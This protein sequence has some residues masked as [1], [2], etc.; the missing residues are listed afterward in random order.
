MPSDLFDELD[1]P[2]KLDIFDDL[3][4]PPARRDIFD[5]TENDLSRFGDYPSAPA[6]GSSP[7]II[8]ARPLA[9]ENL[10][11]QIG[12]ERD[13]LQGIGDDASRLAD[14][15]LMTPFQAGG[16][17]VR[18]GVADIASGMAGSPEYSGNI[19]AALSGDTLP[20]DRVLAD[21]SKEAPGAATL[22]KI[23]QGIAGSAPLIAVM[24]Q[25][26]LG[27]LVA[28]GFTADMLRHAGPE[29]TALGEEMG[30]PPEE[31]DYDKIT[32]A[33]STLAQTTAFAPLAGAHAGGSTGRAIVDRIA[34]RQAAIRELS[35]QL[36]DEPLEFKMTPDETARL[37][38]G[39]PPRAPAEPVLPELARTG[40]LV[41]R[42]LQERTQRII[43][44]SQTPA[45]D[46]LRAQGNEIIPGA[47]A[48]EFRPGGGQ[49]TGGRVS[50]NRPAEEIAPGRTTAE[51]PEDSL[52]VA[53]V[54]QVSP[55]ASRF[56]AEFSKPDAKVSNMS[57]T[58]DA[59]T[60]VKTG[61]SLKNVA[62]L[63]ALLAAN[64]A[65]RSSLQRLRAKQRSGEKLTAE[66]TQ[67]F[68]GNAG[69]VQFPREAVEVATNYG[70]WSEA[71]QALGPRPRPL[72]ERPLDWQKSPEVRDWLERNGE[73]LGLDVSEIRQGSLKTTA[74]E[75][76]EIPE[77]PSMP[78]VQK[79][80]RELRYEFP[81]G[82]KVEIV[83]NHHAL[84]DA[85]HQAAY[86]QGANP[87][88][89]KGYVDGKTVYI[90]R[91]MLDSAADIRQLFLHEQAGHFATDR[92]L[93]PKLTK[94][95]ESVHDSFTKDALMEE[96]RMLYKK[97]DKARLGREFVARLSENP[98][99][100]PTAWNKI[101]AQFRSW[102]RDIGWVKKVSENDIRVLLQR[103]MDS[104][105][106]KEGG[107]SPDEISLSVARSAK[108]AAE[109][110]YPREAKPPASG[111]A[112]KPRPATV[113]EG[114]P[115]PPDITGGAERMRQSAARATTSEQVPP[116]VQER[117]AE[118]PESFYKS[119]KYKS[120]EEAV[121]AA[122]DAELAAVPK[123]S[124]FH[125]ASQLELSRRLFEQGRTEEGYEVFKN[126]SRQGTEWGQ[127]INQF[128]ML[129]GTT[130]ANIIDL[131]N[132]GLKEAG[133]DP[134]TKK[135]MEV[136]GGKAD[137]SIQANKRLENAKKKWEEDPTDANA[138]AAQKALDEAAK[139]DLE[140]QRSINNYKIRTW[141]QMLK[142]FAQGNPLTP[143]SHVANFVGNTVGAS[144]E[145]SSRGVATLID[146]IRNA[147]TGTGRKITVGPSIAR[148]AAEGYGR[149][150]K[151]SPK[152]L[153]RGTGD[154]IKGESRL[155]LQPFRSFIKAF[156]KNPDV[157]TV[158]GKVPLNERIR[159]ATEG[160]FGIPPETMLRLLSGADR[161]PYEAARARLIAEQAKLKGLTPKQ[162]SMAQKFP[163]L[164]FDK[165]TLAQIKL[166]SADAVFQRPSVAVDKLQSLIRQ[167]GGDWG[168]F[169]FTLLVSP[170]KL[171]PWNLVVRTLQYNPVW[172][173]AESAIKARR[174]DTRGA[175][176]SAGRMVI[177]SML[178]ATGYYLYKNGLIGPSL[179]GR[180][181]SQK[182]RMLSGEV[183]P[184]N[185]VNLSGLDR[186]R[187]GESPAF[188][189]GDETIDLTRGG[190]AAGAILSSVANIGRK[191]ENKPEESGTEFAMSLLRDSTLEQ[192][193]FTINQSF[194]KGVTGALDAIQHGNFGPYVTGVE[195]MLLNV[196][197]P[198]TLTA[199]S[200]ATRNYAPDMKAEGVAD[201]FGKVVKNRFGILGADDYLPAK[202]D[203]FGEKMP[204]TPEGRNS[205]LYHLFDISKGRQVT[206]DPVKLELYRLWRKTADAS[207]IPSIPQRD[208]TAENQT[209]PLSNAL[210]SEFSETV[211]RRRKEIA[212]SLVQ[213][214]HFNELTDEQKIKTMEDAWREGLDYGKAVF[215]DKHQSELKAKQPR[216]GFDK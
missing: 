58:P 125:V 166:E 10:Q 54:P 73:Q 173:A 39:L 21:V 89:I 118:A 83:E 211:G 56:I 71:N 113:S 195:N 90:N 68:F 57:D 183:L 102:L 180:S 33:L 42:A 49:T 177:G 8:D 150:L 215:L 214:P 127:N 72:G 135:Q 25:G 55:E 181:E 32:T 164:F 51:K 212:D 59:V 29:A 187:K 36:K 128:K 146:T 82:L 43:D 198:N 66:E 64:N 61:L 184:P 107:M 98:K 176:I 101:V 152:I 142:A 60:T 144:M 147:M 114:A 67:E 111:E 136:L 86:R 163:E 134:L 50:F 130:P 92:I 84:P 143:M 139:S 199:L 41:D 17:I 193:N 131:V 11:S 172:A 141:P 188:K 103:S 47:A 13:R 14:V 63:D 6:P 159:L 88:G 31:R 3:D 122:G 99:S 174:G 74:G 5:E 9:R 123:E 167:K 169:A 171:T 19:T 108:E 133:R 149:G 35:R 126:V 85:S 80:L 120:V 206:D 203:L 65:A 145:G 81:G 69:K 210:Y 213:N 2:A 53:E 40:E 22:G 170:Y 161:P 52:S 137:E 157:P 95:M 109:E 205:I 185:H 16:D 105:R 94:F 165:E 116:A 155:G 129:K 194:L 79:T 46:L 18:G 115:I 162:S 117:I 12:A 97:A 132:S 202:R 4:S 208:I 75:R 121:A 91:Q 28:A 119:Q 26:A 104:L 48:P 207:V 168:D 76:I 45:I 140:T 38:S 106:A 62:D 37:R 78:E 201:E 93:G 1:A 156:A 189:A 192:A 24:P 200:R 158:G 15:G 190:G 34:P 87:V 204:Q 138:Q 44:P 209:Y 20:I 179:E 182:E 154:V 96:T 160:T 23:S 30:K 77:P 7:D 151:E 186:L 148:A 124:N 197:T 178:Y 112:P 27:K 216:A 196:G 153:A 175:E 191:S 100:N 70:A 110:R